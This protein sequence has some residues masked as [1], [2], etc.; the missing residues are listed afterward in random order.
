MMR[1]HTQTAGCTLTAQQPQNNIVRTTVQALAAILGGTQSLH[2]NSWDEAYALPSEESVQLSLRTQQVLAH[3]S[4]VADVVDPLGGSYYVE[5]LTNQLE[6]EVNKY[7]ERTESMGGSLAALEQGLQMREIH[8]SA[9]DHQRKVESNERT[10]VGVNEFVTETPSI[11][12]LLRVDPQVARQQMERL[13]KVRRERDEAI[14]RRSLAR[15]EEVARGGENTLPA[16]LECVEAYCT[17]GEMCNVFRRV[18][19]EQHEFMSF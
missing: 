12:G 4:G 6:E 13:E 2:V 3:E 5:H 14:T 10:V 8:Q 7:L 18:F 17:L 15:L 16:T 11:N 19:G 1:F 9:Y